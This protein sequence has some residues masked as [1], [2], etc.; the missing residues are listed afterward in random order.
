MALQPI[1]TKLA[2]RD[3]R[4]HTFFEVAQGNHWYIIDP[5]FDMRIRNGQGRIASFEDIQRYLGGDRKALQLSA[6]PSPR[7]KTYLELFAEEV[8]TPVRHPFGGH[9]EA[10]RSCLIGIDPKAD[11]IVQ[12]ED[13]PCSIEQERCWQ[14]LQ[15][16]SN[17]ILIKGIKAKDQVRFVWE[18]QD[19]FLKAIS[20][21]LQQGISDLEGFNPD[22]YLARQ[23][24]FFGRHDPAL[25]IFEHLEQTAQVKF[26]T[27]QSHFLKKDKDR[28]VQLAD[29]LKENIFYR[30]MYRQ[31]TG[32]WLLESDAETMIS[33]GYR[34]VDYDLR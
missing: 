27:A 14:Y 13:G 15:K 16:V 20:M 33:F 26:Y 17:K 11:A 22:M 7:T 31:L 9:V 2:Y 18:V 28:F 4:N 24:Q 19:F 6:E 32:S 29:A 1:F 21:E 5:M 3:V 25:R 34:L 10:S 12:K 23:L 30:Y 8:S